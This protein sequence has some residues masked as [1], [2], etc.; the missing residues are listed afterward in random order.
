ME[1]A[2][3]L[4]CHVGHYSSRSTVMI[5]IALA[6]IISMVLAAA[7]LIGALLQ[8]GYEPLIAAPLRWH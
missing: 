1:I 5:V 8:P 2:S 3:E 4:A 7:A 6:G